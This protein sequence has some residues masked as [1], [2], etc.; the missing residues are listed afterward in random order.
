[1]LAHLLT[2]R[3]DSPTERRII[4]SVVTVLAGAQGGS[5]LYLGRHWPE[6][7]V[8]GWLFGWLVLRTLTRVEELISTAAASGSGT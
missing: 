6:D 3:W 2:Q 8:G 4:W 5:R 1:L 7:V